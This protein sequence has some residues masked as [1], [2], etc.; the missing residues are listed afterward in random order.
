MPLTVGVIADT[1]IPDRV[2]ELHPCIQPLF[3]E[4]GV[5]HILH[6]G[7]ICSTQVIKQLSRVAPVTAVRGNRDI[8]VPNLQMVEYVEVGGARI[9]LVHGHG[10][11]WKYLWDKW[12]FWFFGYQLKRY[13]PL[14]TRAAAS[15]QAV[16]FGH[17]HHPELLMHEGRLLFNPGSASFGYLDRGLPS[18]G[19]LHISDAGEV[20]G[21]IRI[22]EGFQVEKR[23]W[24]KKINI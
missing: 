17:T 21:E 13:L 10:S 22:L 9:A 19:F 11:L 2:S 18:L 24:V 12:Q 8:M 14:L 1:H 5:S 7:D 6:A 23:K 16:V 15:A 4:V 20:T 3:E